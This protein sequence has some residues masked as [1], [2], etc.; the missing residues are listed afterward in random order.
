MLNDKYIEEIKELTK[1]RQAE[2]ER[3]H[4]KR[5]GWEIGARGCFE[6]SMKVRNKF[7]KAVSDLL[8]KK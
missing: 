7:N 4:R 5:E 2:L 8:S 1:E 6:E 3:I